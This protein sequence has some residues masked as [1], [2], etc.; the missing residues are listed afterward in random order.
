[1]DSN[2]QNV[3]CLRLEK[4]YTFFM[5]PFYYEGNWGKIYQRINRWQPIREDLY[6]EDVLYPYIMDI[7]SYESSNNKSSLLVYEF[8]S[9]DNGINSQLFVD[10]IL[11]KKQIALLGKNAEEKKNPKQVAF[12]LLNEG[13]FAPHLFVSPTAKIG[14]LTFS[15]KFAETCTCEQQASLNYWLHKRNE[16]D[17]Y[18]CV[19]AKPE[20]QEETNLIVDDKLQISAIS[21]IWKKN[22]KNTRKEV[23]YVCWNINDFVDCIMGTMGVPREDEKR[24]S[25][26]SGY[27]MHLFSFCSIQ[28]PENHSNQDEINHHLIRLSRCVNSNYLLLFDDL[29]KDGAIL[30][31]YENIFF[32][33]AIEG[34][35]MLCIG[36]KNNEKFI[37]DIHSKFNRQYLLI[38]IL[39]LLQRYTLQS[40]ERKLSEYESTDKN[41]DEQLWNLIDIVCRIKINCYYTDVSVYTHHSQFYQLCCKNMHIP[42]TFKEVGEKIELLRLTTNRN[43]QQAQKKSEQ[44][45]RLLNIIVAILTIAQVMQA[46]Y[47]LSTAKEDIGYAIVS[48]K[49]CLCLIILAYLWAYFKDK[50]TIKISKK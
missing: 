13:N 47:E 29:M 39:V 2:I 26:F 35:S 7:F 50:F 30:Q 36:K 1:M 17:K 9:S 15:I 46:V 37:A 12:T 25:Y 23:E 10:R 11:G 8:C 20:K 48:G 5:V 22:Q 3:D 24:I 31:T 4:A 6:T 41:S 14:L 19:C 40:I 45:Q 16:L 38:Y 49:I 21:G 34:T 42:E 27:R 33:S 28:D 18:Q 44:L 32:A 43:I